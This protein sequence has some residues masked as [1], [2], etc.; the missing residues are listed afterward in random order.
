[1]YEK[2]FDLTGKCI[3]ITGGT[4][5]LGS[6]LTEALLTF[7]AGVTVADI[8]FKSLPI[9]DVAEEEGRLLSVQC[10]ISSTASIREALRQH[11]EAR[12]RLDVLINC[13]HYGAG[14]GKAAEIESMTD[15]M[16][17]RGIDGT[18][19]ATFRCIREAVPYL[20]MDG[21]AII[22][23]A[24]MYGMVSPDASVY[25][26]SGANNPPNYGAGKAAVIQ[27]TRYCAAHLAKYGIRCNC[28]TPGPFPDPA[29]NSDTAFLKRLSAKTMLGRT[30]TASEVAGAV[31][32]LASDASSYMTGS[33]LVV[34][35]G[36]TAW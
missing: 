22:N 28:I 14:Y 21:G 12:G 7:G 2:I 34:D 30:G 11:H 26:D 17:N 36:W 31:L 4:G 35:G 29:S 24:S 1:M 18:G 10:D 15:E 9:W 32:L 19:G 5:Y 25:G 16:W 6:A 23:F 8:T 27:L 33:N 13:A 3:L 20:K